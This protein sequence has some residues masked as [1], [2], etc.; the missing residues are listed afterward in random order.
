VKDV[1]LFHS[2]YGLRDAVLDTAEVLRA[3]GHRVTAP[4]LY[5]GPVARSIEEGFEISKRVGWEVIVGRARDAVRDVPADAVLAGLSMGAGVVGEL[6]AERPDTAGLLLLHGV[7]G[8]PR[9][10]RRGLPVQVHVGEADTMF[11][12]A[13]VAAWRS[14]MTAAGAAVEVFT[15]A[16]VRHFF[17]DPGVDEHDEAAASRAWRRSIEFLGAL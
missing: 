4:D 15:Y 9:D 3:A 16:G 2:L 13:D 8:R 17:T 7:G 11:P 1:V 12:P 6:L 14:A 5:D 10:V